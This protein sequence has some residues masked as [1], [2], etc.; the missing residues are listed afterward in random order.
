[1]SREDRLT[2]YARAMGIAVRK[3]NK[4][5]VGDSILGRLSLIKEQQ[6]K[7]AMNNGTEQGV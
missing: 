7:E 6:K 2:A 1:M 4:E 3:N 5:P